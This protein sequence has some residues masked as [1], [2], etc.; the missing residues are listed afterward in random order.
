MMSEFLDVAFSKTNRLQFYDKAGILDEMISWEDVET[1]T[2]FLTSFFGII[3]NEPYSSYFFRHLTKSC[4]P[5]WFIVLKRQGFF[6]PMVQA[7]EDE[8]P[9]QSPRL[10]AIDYLVSVASKFP[11]DVMEVTENLQ[12][13]NA[14]GMSILVK[15]FTNISA[16][17]APRIAPVVT[18]WLNKKLPVSDEI[19]TL[20]KHWSINKQWKHSLILH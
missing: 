15:A 3:R 1:Y 17:F 6:L 9:F 16:D 4:N 20:I 14:F 19:I 8:G 10:P 18:D 5:A 12:I 2:T 13:E 11:S 7:V